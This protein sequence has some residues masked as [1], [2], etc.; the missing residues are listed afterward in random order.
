MIV[1]V[2][3]HYIDKENKM[4]IHKSNLSIKPSIFLE[5]KIYNYYNKIMVKSEFCKEI[6]KIERY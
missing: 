3:V 1:S 6:V 2:K 4:Q 5:N